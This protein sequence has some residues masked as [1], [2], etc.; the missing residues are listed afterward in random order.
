[1]MVVKAAEIAENKPPCSS[2]KGSPSSRTKWVRK[3]EALEDQGN[4]QGSAVF[5]H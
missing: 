5:F 1:M 4:V 2:R 3:G